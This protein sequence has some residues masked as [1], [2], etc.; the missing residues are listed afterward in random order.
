MVDLSTTIGSLSLANPVMPA[1]GTFSDELAQ[2]ID[3]DRIGAC[4]IKTITREFRAG[5]PTPRVAETGGGMLNSIGIPSKGLGDFLDRIV[6]VYRRIQAPLIASVSAN[7]TADFAALCRDVSV[8]GVE[9]IEV[10]ISCP[11]LEADGHAFAMRPDL[12][13]EVITE[14]RKATT[15]PIWAKLT[16][17]TGDIAGVAR[18]AEAGGAD[19]VV[20]ANTILGMSI[21]LTTF[22][23]SLGSGM[24]GFSGP[25]VKPILLRM[26]YQCSRAV[27]IPVIGCGGISTA[28][29]ALEYI[30]AGC[31]AIQVGTAT[32]VHPTA[33]ITVLE[34]LE[35]FCRERGLARLMDI[36]GAVGAVGETAGD[37]PAQPVP[38]E[39]V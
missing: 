27:S 2:V 22:R 31:S 24:G 32:F 29:D 36:R 28:S 5:N 20:V 7:T 6:P 30:V 9:A 37:L 19:A 39:A 26:A 25:A 34:G 16:P 15:L 14:I 21:D 23:P 11:N 18:A 33:M 35:A 4:V 8:D 1:S 12:T 17:N 3:L 10:N 38:A 13:E